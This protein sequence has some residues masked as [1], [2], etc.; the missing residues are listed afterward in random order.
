MSI[1]L[2]AVT[3]SGCVIEPGGYYPRVR[4]RS[5]RPARIGWPPG[6]SSFAAARP[7]VH[8]TS[9]RSRARRTRRTSPRWLRSI[10]SPPPRSVRSSDRALDPTN[11]SCKR[12]PGVGQQPPAPRQRAHPHCRLN[13]LGRGR[14]RPGR[15]RGAG[16]TGGV[17]RIA[18][19]TGLSKPHSAIA[20]T[21][22]RPEPRMGDYGPNTRG[23]LMSNGRMCRQFRLPPTVGAWEYGPAA[24]CRG[25]SP[26]PLRCHGAMPA[27]FP[28]ARLAGLTLRPLLR[29]HLASFTRYDRDHRDGLPAATRLEFNDIARLGAF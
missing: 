23:T 3:L 22:S 18:C 20:A 4:R 29:K 15:H 8:W 6:P 12:R 9:C 25:C 13:T 1:A 27:R 21:A 14:R 19:G 11:A 17:R 7:P 10:P 28:R 5:S 2:A 26:V 16:D 24:S